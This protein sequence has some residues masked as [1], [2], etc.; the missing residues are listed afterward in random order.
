MTIKVM[1]FVCLFLL[2]LVAVEVLAQ[3]TIRLINF[4]KKKVSNGSN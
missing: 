2:V 4:F 3:L 1:L